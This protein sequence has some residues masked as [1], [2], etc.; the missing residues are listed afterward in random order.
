[1]LDKLNY[2]VQYCGGV[3][4]H[5]LRSAAKIG[6]AASTGAGFTADFDYVHVYA[7]P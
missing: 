3:W 1:M 6:L 2:T 5:N 7:L 4:V